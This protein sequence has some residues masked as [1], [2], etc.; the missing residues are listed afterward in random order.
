[1]TT[2]QAIISGIALYSMPS[3]VLLALLLCRP[4][5]DRQ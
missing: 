5:F 3:V 1:M 2:I 4:E